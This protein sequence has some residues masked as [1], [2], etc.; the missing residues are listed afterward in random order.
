MSSGGVLWG[1]VGSCEFLWVLWGVGYIFVTRERR[2][3]L[4]CMVCEWGLVER[5]GFLVIFA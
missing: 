4:A 1:L 2:G 5:F 3:L